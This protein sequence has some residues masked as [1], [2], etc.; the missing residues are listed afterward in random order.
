MRR[1]RKR[2]TGLAPQLQVLLSIL[3]SVPLAVVTT[4]I[5][6]SATAHKLIWI[7]IV[8]VVL[9]AVFALSRVPAGS[10]DVPTFSPAQ[11]SDPIVI[12]EI[13]REPAAF[14]ARGMIDRLAE[15]VTGQVAV[16]YAVTGMRGVGKTQ[17]AAAYARSCVNAGWGLVG[18]VKAESRD[19]LLAGMVR[20]A[21]A[22]GVA[23]P[24]SWVFPRAT[25]AL[26]L[27]RRRAIRR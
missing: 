16:L 22:V 7:V 9:I 11:Q 13:P 20:V 4:F 18:W 8:V 21:H 2:L 14:V 10:A 19:V 23:D 25:W 26:S 6:A 24:F 5:P 1:T 27:P 15:V 3:I 12:G 17:V